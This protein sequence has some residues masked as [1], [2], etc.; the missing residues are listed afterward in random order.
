[1]DSTLLIGLTLGMRHGADPDHLAAIDGLCR[2]RPRAT[3][4]VLFALGHGLVVSALAAGVGQVAAGH[5]AFIG[6]WL[7][8]AIGFVNLWKLIRPSSRHAQGKRPII[9]Q[10]LLLGMLLAAGFET[11][12][13]LSALVLADRTNSW[14]LGVAFC[15]GMML[16]DGCDGYLAAGTQ[17]LAS[18]GTANA[19]TAARAFGGLVVFFSFGLAGAEWLGL[20]LDRLALPLGLA[21]FAAVIGVRLW[22][23][24]GSPVPGPAREFIGPRFPPLQK[25]HLGE[26]DA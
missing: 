14:V 15:A 6:P 11:A 25:H 8:L 23:R 3:N 1:M 10:P 2:I 9:A 4:G 26:I 18:R 19:R 16:V 17:R 7:L 22:A 5:A 13:Q 12:S 21:L 20:A 24:A